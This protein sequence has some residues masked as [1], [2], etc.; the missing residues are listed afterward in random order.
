MTTGPNPHL[1]YRTI[2]GL[3]DMYF[4]PGPT[5]EDVVKQYLALIGR[6]MLPAYFALGFQVK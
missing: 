5:P 1:V 3:L 6:P 2:G 4:F